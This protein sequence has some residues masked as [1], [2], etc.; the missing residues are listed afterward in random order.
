[1]AESV[2]AMNQ[3]ARH[4]LKRA[5]AVL[6]SV[7]SPLNVAA[8]EMATVL[9]LAGQGYMSGRLNNP[10]VP[11]IGAPV[12]LVAVLGLY[13]GALAN[14]VLEGPPVADR[15]MVNSGTA[16]LGGMAF[17]YFA[18]LGLSHRPATAQAASVPAASKGYGVGLATPRH[19]V[20]GGAVPRHNITGGGALS[21]T[22]AARLAA[23]R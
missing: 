12:E 18:G 23:Q 3:A 14:M 8:E 15:C 13:A 16:L 1:M 9:T 11:F 6:Q 20:I 5:N 17:K 7:E 10:K 4:A 22:E 19:D 2:D 21:A